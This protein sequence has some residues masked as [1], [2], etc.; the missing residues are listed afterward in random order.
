MNQEATERLPEWRKI[1]LF[2]VRMYQ[3][4]S[5]PIMG[6]A[7]RETT[8]GVR[9]W[10][11]ARLSVMGVNVVYSPVA[12][13]EE[14]L[15]LWFRLVAGTNRVPEIIAGGYLEYVKKF[16][17][18]GYKMLPM[19]LSAGIPGKE[20][21]VKDAPAA[22]GEEPAPLEKCPACQAMLS[23]WQ[24][25][26]PVLEIEAGAV[27]DSGEPPRRWVC[28]MSAPD[29]RERYPNYTPPRPLDA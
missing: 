16:M 10:A 21:S 26:Y 11:P 28:E 13:C 2:P 29:I 24:A 14:Y 19:V 15:D 3:T 18:G 23:N 5:G 6:H 9:L 25:H 8:G 27:S 17:E 7:E 1:R 12:F 22:G 4:S 20:H